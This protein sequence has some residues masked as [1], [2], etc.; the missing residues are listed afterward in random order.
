M[1]FLYSNEKG[2]FMEN[3]FT[4]S[5]HTELKRELT[6]K[7]ERI[8]IAFLNS[9]D[10]GI[11]YFGIDNDGSVIGLENPDTIQLQI[12]DRIKNNIRGETLGLFDIVLEKLDG[13]NIVKVIVSSGTEKPYYLKEKGMT[14][15]GCFIRNGSRVENMTSAMIEKAFARRTRNTLSVIKSPRQDLKFEQLQIFYQTHRK[16]LNDQFASSLSF[17][18][19]DG[20]YNLNA[21]LFA[22]NND[23]TIKVAKF[24]GTDKTELIENEEYGFCSI[25]KAC[26]DV[27]DKLNVENRTLARI[28]YPFRQEQRLVDSDSLRE[29]V[30][31]A[32]V[33]NDYSDLMSPAFYIFSDRLE[34]VSYGGLIDGMSKE[35]LVSG[36]S[37][38]RNREI[39]RIFKD[40]DLVEQLGTGMNKMMKVYTPDIFTVSPNFFHT[41]F[42]YKSLKNENVPNV[43]NPDTKNVPNVPND[44]ISERQKVIL[45]LLRND[46]NLTLAQIAKECDVVEKTIKRDIAELKSL[47]L[48]S[49]EGST[50]GKWHV[51]DK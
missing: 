16:K 8:V 11:I 39:M 12:A 31:N 15:E 35:E 51:L 6:D 27:L 22:D 36:C 28:T 25:I 17:L 46:G 14:S 23:I 42:T 26:K 3:D 49:R 7:L 37:R 44:G 43:P 20:K 41:V 1:N 4:E 19:E 21:F 29:A 10:G 18:T 50:R 47:K 9:K 24:A 33:H 45:N 2:I 5:Q 38:P 13:K 30:I 48:I 34:I 40:V 32:F